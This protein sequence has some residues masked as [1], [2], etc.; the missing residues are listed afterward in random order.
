M[1]ASEKTTA[2]IAIVT[3]RNQSETAIGR[4]LD[5][6]MA[7]SRDETAAVPLEFSESVVVPDRIIG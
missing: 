3:R 1:S 4:K 6:S 7:A 5:D 2:T